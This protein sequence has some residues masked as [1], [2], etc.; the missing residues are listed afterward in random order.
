MTTHV[1][2][3]KKKTHNSNI[4]KGKVEKTYL[5]RK[6]NTMFHNFFFKSC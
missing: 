1:T 6:S 2:H 3:A 5:I 4:L